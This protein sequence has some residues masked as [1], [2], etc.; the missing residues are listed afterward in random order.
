MSSSSS[1]SASSPPS[2][3]GGAASPMEH[4]S[5]STSSSSASSPSSGNGSGSLESLG[6][7]GGLAAVCIGESSPSACSLSSGSSPPQSSSTSSLSTSASSSSIVKS[8]NSSMMMVG[9]QSSQ[10]SKSGNNNNNNNTNV[11]TASIGSLILSSALLNGG[12]S[13]AA[14][15]AAAA[16]AAQAAAA[17]QQQ[18]QES[19]KSAAATIPGTASLPSAANGTSSS[20]TF[21][22][23]NSA[24]TTTTTAT[25]VVAAAQ[26]LGPHHG[27]PLSHYQQQQQLRLDPVAAAAAAAQQQQNQPQPGD[28]QQ[29]ICMICEDRA[30]GLHYGIITC[31]G[32]KGFFKRTVQNKRVYTCV[33]DGQCLIT[34]QQRNRCQYC[35][36]QKCLRQGMV[37]AAVREDRMPGG[38]NSGA[39]YNLYKVKYRKHKKPGSNNSSSSSPV[40]TNTATSL[41]ISSSQPNSPMMVSA[42][43]TTTTITPTTPPINMMMNGNGSPLISNNHTANHTNPFATLNGHHVLTSIARQMHLILANASSANDGNSGE[44][45]MSR[46]ESDQYLSA[47]IDCDDFAEFGSLS[48]LEL[49]ET[50]TASNSN[51]LSDRLCSIGDSIVY[52]LVQWTKRLPFYEQLPVHTH[53]QLLTHKWH[54][55][56]VLSTCAFSAINS[57]TTCIESLDME[58]RQCMTN[59]AGNLSRLNATSSGT[60]ISCAQLEMEAGGL[61]SELCAVRFAFK[62][63]GLTLNEFV[64]LKVIAMTSIVANNN[65]EN[66]NNS[67]SR[68]DNQQQ[69]PDIADPN[70]V[71]KIRDRYLKALVSHLIHKKPPLGSGQCSTVA[72]LALN[73]MAG[74][75]NVGGNGNGNGS[76][77]AFISSLNSAAQTH[78]LTSALGPNAG[79]VLARMNSLLNLLAQVLVPIENNKSHEN[80]CD[81]LID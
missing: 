24:T 61:V 35:R 18:Q 51:E 54:E 65:N 19:Q 71:L 40:G 8:S 41:A 21:S 56:L 23:S 9:G 33:A 28:N 39:V 27:F 36:F 6:I 32:C 5:H 1:S 4:Q 22:G 76:S 63:L 37:L 45:L 52:R 14:A 67:G 31:E 13:A 75:G 72:Q 34:K 44:C 15:A 78:N 57:N 12:M 16:I 66:I 11:S 59:L 7:N 42:N 46:D 10:I 73:G 2:N 81:K 70:S 43:G 53:T 74:G 47:L 64:A 62:S 79:H 55:L 68:S 20:L 77:A 17:Q 50:S 3:V 29:M 49:T 80:N 38:R 48:A 25:A 30:T 60:I 58:I 69:Q 26:Q